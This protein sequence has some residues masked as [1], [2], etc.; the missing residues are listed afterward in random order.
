MGLN[1]LFED[2]KTDCLF[3]CFNVS[4]ALMCL[5]ILNKF[6]IRGLFLGL[7]LPGHG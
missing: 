5:M 1:T 6:V 3:F 4:C 7:L 2:F